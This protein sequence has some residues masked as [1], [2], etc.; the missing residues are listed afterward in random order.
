MGKNQWNQKLKKINSINKPVS[1][2]REKKRED[3]NFSIR[4]RRKN[5]ITNT[6]TS[7]REWGMLQTALYI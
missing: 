7:K 5:I 6:E 2:P 3:A 1:R 4:N